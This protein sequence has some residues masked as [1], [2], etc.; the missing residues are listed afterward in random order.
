MITLEE[1][2]QIP[3]PPSP[4]NLDDIV[5]PLARPSVIFNNLEL[6]DVIAEPLYAYKEERSRRW[7]NFDRRNM[8]L[9]VKADWVN[10]VAVKVTPGNAFKQTET[11][12]EGIA[13]STTVTEMFAT[14]IGVKTG[15][16]TPVADLG[17]DISTTL[18]QS[19]SQTFQI[20]N[21]RQ[22]STEFTISTG[23]EDSVVWLWQL[24]R[25][26]LLSGDLVTWAVTGDKGINQ[27][28]GTNS[29]KVLT[30]DGE[31]RE[32]T[33]QMQVNGAKR[34]GSSRF[35][36]M[37]PVD[38]DVFVFTAFPSTRNVTVQMR[39]AGQGPVVIPSFTGLLQSAVAEADETTQTAAA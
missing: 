13:S 23:D 10:R 8:R 17:A 39:D 24:N 32:R 21:N 36:Q 20:S 2:N 11:I 22:V 26:Y 6:K 9:Q 33:N 31:G 37:L 18:S 15:I 12:S 3:L 5:P 19:T 7:V 16:S 28:T 38:S 29:R 4:A 27:L 30:R 25:A 34:E 14:T 1:S 35:E